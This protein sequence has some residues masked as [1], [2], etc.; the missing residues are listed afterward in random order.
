MSAG[1][2]AGQCGGAGCGLGGTLNSQ[3]EGREEGKDGRG[4]KG[5]GACCHKQ[6]GRG[7]GLGPRVPR[8]T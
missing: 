4:R 1:P 3:A 6:G 8:H 7:S 5:A 2:I